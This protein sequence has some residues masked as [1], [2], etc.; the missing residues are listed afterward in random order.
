MN[1]KNRTFFVVLQLVGALIWGLAFAFQSIGME[2]T[3]PFTFTGVRFFL[4]AAV[5]YAFSLVRDAGK[6]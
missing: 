3:G 5:V 1:K 4:A 6:K 2:K